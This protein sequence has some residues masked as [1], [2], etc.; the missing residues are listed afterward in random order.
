MNTHA[1]LPERSSI[2]VLTSAGL[3]LRRRRGAAPLEAVTRTA[4]PTAPRLL[5][6]RTLELHDRA[7]GHLRGS[8]E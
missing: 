5:L 6:P 1:C 4:G 8:S 7:R 3:V 2:S